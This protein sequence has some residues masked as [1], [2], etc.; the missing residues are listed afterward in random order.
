MNPDHREFQSSDHS[1]LSVGTGVQ[2][3]AAGAAVSRQKTGSS[4]SED[5]VEFSFPD[6]QRMERS[7]EYLIILP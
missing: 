2:V 1:V 6:G 3:T 5:S 7:S 4:A